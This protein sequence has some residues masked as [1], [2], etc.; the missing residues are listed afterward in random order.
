MTPRTRSLVAVA[1][2]EGVLGPRF[3]RLSLRLSHEGRLAEVV[4][5][6]AAV[7][8]AR[9][10]ATGRVPPNRGRK[11]Q[12]LLHRVEEALRRETEDLRSRGL[13]ILAKEWVLPNQLVAAMASQWLR[14]FSEVPVTTDRWDPV[15]E[16]RNQRLAIAAQA[17]AEEL[18]ARSGADAAAVRDRG[19]PLRLD[20]PDFEALC[21]RLAL[22]AVRAYRDPNDA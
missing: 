12:E 21:R 5:A 4:E 2:S 18:I 16:E 6:V 8:L 15:E 20:V 9:G 13:A 14:D 3:Q 10:L 7:T 1:S 11:T 17:V 22:V 19:D